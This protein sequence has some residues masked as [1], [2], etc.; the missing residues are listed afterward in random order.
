MLTISSPVNPNTSEST[1][2]VF[3]SSLKDILVPTFAC[4]RISVPNILILPAPAFT[5]KLWLVVSILTTSFAVK[6]ILLVAFNIISLPEFILI[7]VMLVFIW[8]SEF[9]LSSINLILSLMLW[10]YIVLSWV[11][12]SVLI[13]KPPISILFEYKLILSAYSSIVY[14]LP[15]LLNN[16]HKI[17]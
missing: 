12:I 14:I 6:V 17:L 3:A 9:W 13:F 1:F 15:V 5:L 11:D 10:E 8:I 2:I 16:F 7:S 4:I